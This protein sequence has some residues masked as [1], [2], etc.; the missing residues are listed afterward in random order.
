MSVE[1]Q[2]TLAEL[3]V[4]VGA[5]VQRGQDV[6]VLAMDVGQAPL[7]RSVAESAYRTGARFVSALYWDAHV[8]LARL[9]HAPADTLG[10]IPEWWGGLV[11]GCARRGSA[12]IILQQSSTQLFEDIDPE[13]AVR[14]VMPIPGFF[15]EAVDGGH[16]V[17]TAV[18]GVCPAMAQA[19]LGHADTDAVWEVLAPLLRLDEPDP[20]S[21]W[22]DHIGRLQRRAAQLQDRGF[23]GLRFRGGGTDLSVGLL[24]GAR[25]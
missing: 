21:A 14:E 13:L 7:V 17:W 25:W 6:V 23:N 5:N 1:R 4:T 12:V 3:A 19:M 2:Q 15:W 10:F 9:R 18:P 20:G 24:P 8:K 11:A 16:I 22:R